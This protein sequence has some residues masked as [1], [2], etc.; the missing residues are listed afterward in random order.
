MRKLWYNRFERQMGVNQMANENDQ[1]YARKLAQIEANE[2][3]TI[4]SSMNQV[5]DEKVK[6]YIVYTDYREN[7][8]QESTSS[9]FVYT[10]YANV[11]RFGHSTVDFQ[12]QL[13]F[14][15]NKWKKEMHITVLETLGAASRLAVYDFQN[16]GLAQLAVKAFCNLANKLEIETIDGNI[17]TF[18]RDDFKK[19]AHILEKY[20]FEV[21]TDA[22]QSSGSF[23]KT[24]K[25]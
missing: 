9:I 16:L 10:P 18:D 13:L 24:R 21:Q 15:T 6:Q 3:L 11:D 2:N 5:N 4:L 14:E 12:T 23:I 7:G 25:A 19:V 20:E 17:S 22:G 8:Q 1:A